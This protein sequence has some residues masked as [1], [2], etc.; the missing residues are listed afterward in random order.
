MRKK[1]G[2]Q[3]WTVFAKL[4]ALGFGNA[5]IVFTVGSMV[6]VWFYVVQNNILITNREYTPVCEKATELQIELLAYTKGENTGIEVLLSEIEASSVPDEQDRELLRTMNAYL[7]EAHT[8]AMLL[9]AKEL[10]ASLRSKMKNKQRTSSTLIE[11]ALWMVIGGTIFATSLNLVLSKL[12]GSSISK[13]MKKVVEQLMS[14]SRELDAAAF[15]LSGANQN[16]AESNST[17]AS[18]IEEC[19][20]SLEEIRQEAKENSTNTD[21]TY[22]AMTDANETVLKAEKVISELKEVMEQINQSANESTLVLSLIDDIAFQTNLLALNAAVEA[23]RAGEAGKGFAVVAE[24]VRNLAQRSSE[25]ARNTAGILNKSG[26]YSKQGKLKVEG[27]VQ[28]FDQIAAAAS[29][30]GDLVAKINQASG[31]QMQSI[32][33]VSKLMDNMEELV[34]D[35]AASAEETAGS[36]EELSAQAIELNTTING[37]QRLFGIANQ[38]G[39]RTSDQRFIEKETY[40]SAQ[41]MEFSEKHELISM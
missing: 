11:W 41:Q 5:A 12:L 35:N 30:I 31:R 39:K 4:K 38:T 20:V 3:N 28:S 34:Q 13:D 7:N 29:G 14:S 33:Q 9:P 6:G 24:E 37:L 27:A 1:K 16:L 17:Q 18:H 15:Q 2:A 40:E 19:T 21:R 32:D 25:A 10:E 8:E 22:R 36:A 26:E 23:A